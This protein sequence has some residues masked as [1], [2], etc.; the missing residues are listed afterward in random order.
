M[1][2]IVFGDKIFV[3]VIIE[4]GIG[5]D[6]VGICI[7]VEDKGDYWVLNGFKVYI[8]NG[9]IFDVVL[10]VVCIY[11]DNLYVMGFFIVEVGMEGF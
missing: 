8:F 10:V 6:M 3:I 7:C 5:F 2:G 1:L 9:L 11:F 4:F